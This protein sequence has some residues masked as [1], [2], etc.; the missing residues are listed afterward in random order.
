MYPGQLPELCLPPVSGREVHE[1]VSYQNRMC[2]CL[3][4]LKG[5]PWLQMPLSRALHHWKYCCL[6]RSPP[7]NLWPTFR[8]QESVPCAYHKPRALSLA[9]ST[10]RLLCP[11]LQGK[12]K[13]KEPEPLLQIR[14]KGWLWNWGNKSVLTH[15]SNRKRGRL[16]DHPNWCGKHIW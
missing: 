5:S 16:Y 15:Y 14:P 11:L 12:K 13:L 6:E 7:R 2:Y 3:G 8:T 9:P 4:G 10:G 1:E